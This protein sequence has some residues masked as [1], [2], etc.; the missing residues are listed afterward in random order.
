MTP[1]I[2][3][4]KQ[5]RKQKPEAKRHRDPSQNRGVG[6]RT[7]W[8]SG[9]WGSQWSWQPYQDYGYDTREPAMQSCFRTT[10]KAGIYC[11]TPGYPDK[12]EMW[13][14]QLCKATSPWPESHRSSGTNV[15]F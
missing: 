3:E 11:M 2:E 1:E 13:Y 5:Q 10:C 8:S 6:V 4:T 12:N 9:W 15:L 14:R 7:N